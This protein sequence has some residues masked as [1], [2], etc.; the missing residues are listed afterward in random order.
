MSNSFSAETV[1]D[2]C[3]CVA[4][5]CVTHSYSDQARAFMKAQ[6]E[7]IAQEV[8]SWRLDDHD[9][10]LLVLRPTW[11]VMVYKYGSGLGRRLYLDF[12]HSYWNHPAA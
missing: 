11:S 2:R 1:I 10:N 5:R 3:L 12:I 9:Q 6:F 7:E 8:A 4:N